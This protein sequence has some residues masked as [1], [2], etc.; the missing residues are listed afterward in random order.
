MFHCLPDSAWADGN[1]AEAAGHDGG[2]QISV[3]PTHV[4]AHLGPLYWVV[5]QNWRKKSSIFIIPVQR[6]PLETGESIHIV[7]E[8]YFDNLQRCYVLTPVPPVD[9]KVNLADYNT[10][11]GH[12]ISIIIGPPGEVEVGGRGLQWTYFACLKHRGSTREGP[13]YW[14]PHHALEKA[15]DNLINQSICVKFDKIIV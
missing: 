5:M 1:L 7:D 14:Q 10:K 2:T 15:T 13:S 3:N 4:S 9:G 8:E 11:T 12:N 6:M